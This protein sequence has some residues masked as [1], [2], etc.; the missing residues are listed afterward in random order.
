M[1]DRRRINGP[2][3][4]TAPPVYAKSIA[5]NSD[6]DLNRPVRTRPPNVLR[7]MCKLAIYIHFADP[8]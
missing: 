5:L 2:I 6:G 1:N 3:G 7:K 4:G 8:N